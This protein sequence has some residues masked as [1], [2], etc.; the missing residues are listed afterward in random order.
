[1]NF[2]ENPYRYN[3][4]HSL[5]IRKYLIDYQKEHQNN[6]LVVFSVMG[7][8]PRNY[9][10]NVTKFSALC[11]YYVSRSNCTEMVKFVFL[12]NTKLQNYWLMINVTYYA[13]YNCLLTGPS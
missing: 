6:S 2:Q 8:Q 12:R 3:R 4:I 11:K 10:L 5:S 9:Q 13:A 1:M 7:E